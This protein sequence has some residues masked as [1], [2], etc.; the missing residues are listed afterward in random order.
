MQGSALTSVIGLAVL[1]Q[2]SDVLIFCCSFFL[3]FSVQRRRNHVHVVESAGFCTC[4]A[5]LQLIVRCARLSA[6]IG[7]RS[8]AHGHAPLEGGCLQRDDR[9]RIVAS[10]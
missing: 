6:P 5:G 3:A 9:R 1:V 7:A 10:L 2:R 4:L 8:G